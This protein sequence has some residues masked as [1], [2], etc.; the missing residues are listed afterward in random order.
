MRDHYRSLQSF[1]PGWVPLHREVLERTRSAMITI[2]LDPRPAGAWPGALAAR[3][4]E[5]SK[6]GQAREHPPTAWR[7]GTNAET[8]VLDAR[9][10]EDFALA[11]ELAPFSAAVEAM[12]GNGQLL[13]AR[14]RGEDR[15]RLRL[16][17]EEHSE[18]SRALP[19]EALPVLTPVGRGGIGSAW[20]GVS[21]RWVWYW[22]VAGPLLGFVSLNSSVPKL[23]DS[24]GWGLISSALRVG[25]GMV[26]IG[27][28]LTAL[29]YLIQRVDARYR[30]CQVTPSGNVTG[31]DYRGRHD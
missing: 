6:R 18:L 3:A 19:A 8:V 2:W 7:F 11:L 23:V 21:R 4:G 16:T 12:S 13:L 1:D 5:L 29:W 20:E 27:C 15:L 14:K 10:D 17:V 31:S 9:N 25:G 28:G 24:S 26:W 22:A 30:R